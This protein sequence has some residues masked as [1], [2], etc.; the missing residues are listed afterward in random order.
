[1]R[2]AVIVVESPHN[3]V[4]GSDGRF[5]IPDVPAGRHKLVIWHTDHDPEE[6]EVTVP[7]NGVARVEVTLG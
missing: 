1:M 5:R 4:V 3:A 7:E 2:S 6:V